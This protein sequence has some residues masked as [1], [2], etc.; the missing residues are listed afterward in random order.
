MP[1]C[2]VLIRSAGKKLTRRAT[3]LQ[4]RG[5]DLTASLSESLQSA[6]EIRAYNLQ[7]P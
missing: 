4:E 7:E 3:A 5:G 2:I 1:L 6:L